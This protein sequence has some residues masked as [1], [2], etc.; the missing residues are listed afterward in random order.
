MTRPLKWLTGGLVLVALVVLAGVLAVVLLLDPAR[1]RDQ[2]VS[3]VREQTGRELEIAQPVELS[4]FPWLG[5][6]LREVTLG[7]APGFGDEPLARAD[8]IRVRV[9]VVPLL[10]GQLEV[11]SLLLRGLALNL[12]RNAQ[13]EVNWADVGPATA[14]TSP[15]PQRRPS[16]AHENLAAFLIGGVELSGGRLAWRDERARAGY[17]IDELELATG[18]IA[19]G[20]AV[21][22]R[23]GAR[24]R[25]DAASRTLTLSARGNLELGERLTTVQ[26]PDLELKAKVEGQGLPASGIQLDS[27]AGVRYDLESHNLA[28]TGLET[29]G[30]ALRVTGEV[31]GTQLDRDPVFEGRLELA[32]A[33]PRPLLALLGVEGLATAD[34]TVLGR[35]SAK[36][37]FKA[38]T[39]SLSLEGLSLTLDDTAVSGRLAVPDLATGALRFDLALDRIDLDRYLPPAGQGRPSSADASGKTARPKAAGAVVAGGAALPVETL[40]GLDLDGSLRVGSLEG[41]GMRLSELRVH[42]QGKGGVL[43]QNAQAKLY[44][45]SGQWTTTLDVR[46]A[47]PAVTLK[48]GLQG[49]DLQ[50]LLADTTGQGRLSGHGGIDADLRWNGLSEDEIRRSLSGS[51]RLALR[52]GA[53][54]GFDLDA[55]VRNALAAVQG[56]KGAG[57][58]TQTAFSDLTASVTAQNGVLTNRDL[59][60]TSALLS[61]T[62]AG[63]LDL[64]ANRIDYLAKATVLESAHGQ[65]GGQLATLRDT[66]I[67]VRF[68][69]KLDAPSIKLDVEEV[70][71]SKAGQQIQRKVE[72]KLKGE[73]GDKLKGILGR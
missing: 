51:A 25:P 45:G 64:P 19:A 43:T 69:G 36:L 11:D 28:V 40:R 61:V 38:G 13:G 31:R 15:S 8:E 44:G 63:T 50:G 2:L 3:V 7:N 55:L 70:L 33:K 35:L 58:G 6:G 5:A 48:G 1:V 57:G 68:T 27:R 59:R 24:V 49:I 71:K 26:V 29:A 16:A 66:P 14:S 17:V 54:Q 30:P 67:P 23:L 46:R 34:P 39:R 73:W 52:D 18:A 56:G 72:E 41:G 12:A 47:P 60:A 20:L 65:L 10:S 22:V 9:K 42:V 53:V 32:D 37:P 4:F 62:G 21:P